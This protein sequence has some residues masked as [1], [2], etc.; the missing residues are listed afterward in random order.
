[1]PRTREELKEAFA[2][3]VND[4]VLAHQRNVALEARVRGLEEA[5]H[6][7]QDELR[8]SY[9]EVSKLQEELRKSQ[10]RGAPLELE[11]LTRVPAQQNAPEASVH[12]EMEVDDNKPRITVRSFAFSRRESHFDI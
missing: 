6:K 9:E 11:L 5:L 7:A 3:I 4:A 12:V 8:A 2:I 10:E 1:M